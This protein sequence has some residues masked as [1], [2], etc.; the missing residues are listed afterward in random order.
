MMSAT[1]ALYSGIL[2]FSVF[3]S[4]VSQVLLKESALKSHESTLRE[5]LNPYVVTAYTIFLLSSLLTVWAYKEVPLSF[6][7]VLEA[8]SY[9]YVTVFGILIFKE[10]LDGRKIFALALILGGIAVY[11]VSL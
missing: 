10:R 1:L 7:P 6:G 5:Y 11:A 4:A 3:I 8:T 9:L 2:L